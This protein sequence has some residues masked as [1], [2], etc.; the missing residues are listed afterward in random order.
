LGLVLSSRGCGVF[1][2]ISD[3]TVGEVVGLSMDFQRLFFGSVLGV[4]DAGRNKYDRYY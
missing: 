2:F 3:G 1:Y 4:N